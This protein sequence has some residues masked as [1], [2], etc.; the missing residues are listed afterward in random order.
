M[1]R[2]DDPEV[3]AWI[4]GQAT[5][6][7]HVLSAIPGRE[8]LYQRIRELDAGAPYQ[9][10]VVRRWPGGDLHYL[11]RL[12]GENLDKLY[13]RND[14]AGVERLLVDPERFAAKGAHAALSFTSASDDGRYVAYGIAAAGS[15]PTT[16]HVIDVAS[17]KDLA[18]TI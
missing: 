17:G 10:H 15:G 8:R 13:V 9:L 6:A 1:E 5:Y 11:K 7:Q 14:K 4:K 16:L 12:A 18:D 3:R 2:L